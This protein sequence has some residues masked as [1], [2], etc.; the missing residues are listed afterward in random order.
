VRNYS[1]KSFIQTN[2]DAKTSAEEEKKQAV[3]GV[4]Y[5]NITFTQE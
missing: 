2:A 5:M 4:K 1:N 3:N